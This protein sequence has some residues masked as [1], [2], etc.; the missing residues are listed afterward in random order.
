MSN[1]KTSPNKRRLKHWRRDL[2]RLQAETRALRCWRGLCK[3]QSIFESSK[4][5]R[6]G[7]FVCCC[8]GLGNIK[9]IHIA[10]PATSACLFSQ[11]SALFLCLAFSNAPWGAKINTKTH[12]YQ[13]AIRRNKRGDESAGSSLLPPRDAFP[14]IKHFFPERDGIFIHSRFHS[15]SF[16]ESRAGNAI[17]RLVNKIINQK[18][19]LRLIAIA[20]GAF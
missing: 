20:D 17:S 8:R 13:S 2:E 9:H 1:P 6:Y 12:I 11:P 10:A 15:S 3:L 16:K 19:T 5:I 18:Y 4:F 14:M 7:W